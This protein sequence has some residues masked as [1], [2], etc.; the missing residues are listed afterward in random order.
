[1][2]VTGKIYKEGGQGGKT[3]WDTNTIEI[4]GKKITTVLQ[5]SL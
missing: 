2:L 3:S 4:S 1:M 5:I